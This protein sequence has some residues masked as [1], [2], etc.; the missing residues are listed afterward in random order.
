M[1]VDLVSTAEHEAAHAV[2]SAVLNRGIHSIIVRGPG[3]GEFHARAPTTSSEA[4]DVARFQSRLDGYRADFETTG[5]APGWLHEALTSWLAG[6]AFD[7]GQSCER[8]YQRASYDRARA[9]EL[10]ESVTRDKAARDRALAYALLHA[11][12]ICDHQREPILVLGA[13]V[14]A[15]GG[16]MER[17]DIMAVLHRAG[18]PRPIRSELADTPAMLASYWF[19]AELGML[20]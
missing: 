11:A 17:D 10:T 7:L 2:V 16:S 13:A 3:D 12:G 20:L 5:Q 9:V 1:N 15:H 14:V 19:C 18:F 4:E 8:A 6:M